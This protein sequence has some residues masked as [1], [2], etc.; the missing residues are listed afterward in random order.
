MHKLIKLA[1]LILSVPI[2]FIIYKGNNKNYINI[3]ILGDGLS[4]GINSYETI[5]YGY[6]DYL[7]DYYQ[8]FGHTIT[9][10][11]GPKDYAISYNKHNW[12]MIDSSQAFIIDDKGEI[13]PL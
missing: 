4:Q 12:A 11:T 3:T 9:F 2:I 7:K 5:D 6:G 1:V 8:V 10:P 13:K